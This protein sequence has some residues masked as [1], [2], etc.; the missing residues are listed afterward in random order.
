QCPHCNTPL[1][2]DARF[3]G[4]CGNSVLLQ[5]AT[6]QGAQSASA[7]PLHNDLTLVDPALPGRQMPP[8]IQQPGTFQPTQNASWQ[9]PPAQATW[10]PVQQPQNAPWPQQP[11][12]QQPGTFSPGMP[13]AVKRRR[14]WPMRVLVVFLVILVLLAGGWFLGVR[15][16][17]NNLAKTQLTRTL[18]DAQSEIVLLQPALPAGPSIIP[19]TETNFNDYLSTHASSQLQDL[20]MSI[21]PDNLRLDFKV[22]GFG[23][24]IIAVPV[25]INGALQVTNV[26]TQGV[27]GLVLSGDELTS[28]LNTF[29]QNSGQQMHR[30][31]DAVSLH[32]QVMSIQIS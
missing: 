7:Q 11:M 30:R 31:I 1:V 3:C 15:P 9:Q 5:S 23:C 22:N 21:T 20:H 19:V 12:Q 29:L 18:D 32:N 13:V 14:K 2:D 17:L 25:A 8:L 16:Y 10:P 28:I 26:Q 24:T 27:L 4:M 6:G